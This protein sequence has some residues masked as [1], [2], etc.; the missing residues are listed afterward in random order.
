MRLSAIENAKQAVVKDEHKVQ[1]G[2]SG[3]QVLVAASFD[4][5]S[6]TIILNMGLAMALIDEPASSFQSRWAAV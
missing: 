5:H 3:T 2:E 6:T 1:R 4:P